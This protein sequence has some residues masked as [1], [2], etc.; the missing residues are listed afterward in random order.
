VTAPV[1]DP[2]LPAVYPEKI[3]A[4][5]LK[6]AGVVVLGSIMAILDITVVNVALPHFQTDLAP[7]DTPLAY[8][9][10]AWTVTAYTLA[11]AS[12]IPLTGWAADRFGTK[13]LYLMAIGFF[14][15]GSTLCAFAPTIETLIGARVLQ[16]LGGGMLMPL[17]MTIMTRAAGPARMGRLMAILG[18]PMLLGPIAGPILGG[19]LIDNAHWFGRP[20]WTWIFLI[21][22]PIGVIA[23]VYA[24][25]VLPKDH[26]EPSESIDV[27][28]L[29]LMSPG[30]ALFLYGV[31]SIPEAGTVMATK[32]LAPALVGAALIAAFGWWSMKPAHPLL[33]LRLLANRN[34]S[35]AALTMFLFAA[36][37]FGGLLLMPTYFQQ[38]RGESTMAAGLLMAPQGIGALVTMPIAGALVDRYPVGRIVPLGIALITGGMFALTQLTAESSYWGFVIPVLFVM[39]LGMGATMMPL[40]TSSL[41]AL[42][43][44]QV[45]RGS[46]ILNITQQ[47]ASSFG[48]AIASVLLTRGFNQRPVIAQAQGFAQASE[49]VQ[50]PSVLQQLLEKFPAI[51]EIAAT[52]SDPSALGVAIQS[53][54]RGEMAEA[55][56]GTYWVSAFLCLTTLVVAAFL[57]RRREESH[58]LDEE[59]RESAPVV[60]H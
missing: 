31:S 42:T 43:A 30:L 45:A 7:G 46:T 32:V 47:V 18:I 56:A 35:I 17:G 53:V 37:F 57:P 13:R 21:N 38:V 23:L 40:M 44:P 51:A 16:G 36:A 24:S 1:H 3:D 11:L 59:P 60:L 4:A 8:S 50:D 48:V 58:L 54:V 15:A 12:V 9:T 33:D 29:L 26:T 22:L 19:W 27:V 41:K 14:V 49:G 34:F 5:V 39:G 20:S 6:V 28:G 52:V 2:S 10:V 55:F 25:L